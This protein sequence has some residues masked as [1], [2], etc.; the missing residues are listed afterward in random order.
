MVKSK[1]GK[2]SITKEDKQF[3]YNFFHDSQ[4][5]QKQLG[6]IEFKNITIKI[7]LLV[8]VNDLWDLLKQNE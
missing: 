7:D 3:Y 5:T 8:I 2:S 4:D 1:K 6:K